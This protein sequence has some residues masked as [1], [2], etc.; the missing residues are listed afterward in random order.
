MQEE[1]S[2]ELVMAIG[3]LPSQ[4]LETGDQAEAGDAAKLTILQKKAGGMRD[5]S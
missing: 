5:T 1:V 3:E 2:S 4:M